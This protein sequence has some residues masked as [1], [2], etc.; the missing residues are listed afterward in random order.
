MSQGATEEIVAH[1][2]L[3]SR[4]EARL[5][6]K[7]EGAWKGNPAELEAFPQKREPAAV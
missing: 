2:D 3:E 7:F 6:G 4:W 1:L 5:R